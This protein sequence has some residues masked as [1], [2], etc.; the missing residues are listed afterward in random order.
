MVHPVQ[1][2]RQQNK[3][4]TC[5]MFNE[6][7]PSENIK[8]KDLE[9]EIFRYTN[10][11]GCLILKDI[12]EK[13]DEKIFNERDKE[14]CKSKGFE[15]T[16]IHTIMGNVPYKRR[17]YETT[18]GCVTKTVYLLDE[19]LKIFSVKKVS[20]NVVEKIMDIVKS[21]TYRDSMCQVIWGNFFLFFSSRKC[22]I[23]F[24]P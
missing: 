21:N 20:G 11:L 2:N 24:Y 9:K 16:S 22:N 7:I 15:G 4:R 1:C 19:Q 17:R 6:I 23:I 10:M 3:E 13:Q 14:K 5:T 12:L 18:K 8:F